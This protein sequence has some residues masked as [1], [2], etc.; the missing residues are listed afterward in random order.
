MKNSELNPFVIGK[1]VSEEYFCDREKETEMLLR[2]VQNG[3]NVTLISD[4]RIGKSGL[5]SHLFAQPVMQKQYYTI[6][7]DLYATSS[8]AELVCLFGNEVYRCIQTQKNSWKEKFFQIISSFRV[9]F[10]LDPVSGSPAFD[11]AIGDIV[12]P[13]MT[14]E[15][16]F[17]YLE[18]SDK[19]CVVAFDEF[20][21]IGEYQEKNVEALLRTHIQRCKKTR[22][23]FAGSRKHVMTQMFLSP[24]KPFYQSTINMGLEPIP[25]EVYVTFA[26]RMFAKGS[27]LIDAEAVERVYTLCR[28]VTWYMQVLLNEMYVLTAVQG[29]CSVA[30]MDMAL[31]NVVLLQEPFY[32]ELLAALPQKQKVVLYAIVKEREA[33]NVASKSFIDKYKLESASSVQTAIKGLYAKDILVKTDDVWRVYDVFFAHYIMRYML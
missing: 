17:A 31:Q 4:R 33:K 29:K 18:E 14:L 30:E 25:K 20:Q 7:V 8:M 10:K 2:Q 24:S 27:K 12:A 11:I 6:S 5:I 26:Q 32:R 19:P 1:Y 9:G 13:V 16:I 23:I 28:G 15:Q 22:F 3:R 21:Q